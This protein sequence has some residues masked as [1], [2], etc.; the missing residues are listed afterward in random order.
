MFITSTKLMC[1]DKIGFGKNMGDPNWKLDRKDLRKI[2]TTF[3]TFKNNLIVKLYT[4]FTSY[5]FAVTAQ[6]NQLL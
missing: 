5:E 6:G 3:E 1:Y 2:G 4:R